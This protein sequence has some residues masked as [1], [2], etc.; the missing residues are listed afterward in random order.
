[1]SQKNQIFFILPL[2]SCLYFILTNI[3]I[4]SKHLSRS[5]YDDGPHLELGS[6]SIEPPLSPPHAV[7][8]HTMSSTSVV[9][10][11]S[12]DSF[13]SMRAPD[14]LQPPERPP[15]TPS[16][17]GL[18]PRTPLSSAINVLVP[19]RHPPYNFDRSRH[20][21]DAMGLPLS[22]QKSGGQPYVPDRPPKPISMIH[23]A[24]PGPIEPTFLSRHTREFARSQKSF[25][26]S[27][28]SV[29][30]SHLCLSC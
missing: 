3:F 15:K 29:F 16:Q 10:S 20:P 18:S 5:S 8:M 12:V 27:G 25:S 24:S 7:L 28:G 23:G 13:P 17:S 1:M 22:K 21:P 14:R 30:V 6:R 4:C 19:E 9:G 26:N 11:S 2:L